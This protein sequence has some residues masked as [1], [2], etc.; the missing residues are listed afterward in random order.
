MLKANFAA[1]FSLLLAQAA[2]AATLSCWDTHYKHTKTPLF[3]ATIAA[4]NTLKDITFN[5]QT[6]FEKADDLTTP[7][8]VDGKEITSNHSPYKGD[9]DYALKSGDRLILPADLSKYALSNSEPDGIGYQKGENGVIIGD[10]SS[11]GDCDGGCH[12]STRLECEADQ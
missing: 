2:G 11:S 6:N 7:G 9:Y 12:V 1:L 3:T 4:S 10:T 8:A 5:Y